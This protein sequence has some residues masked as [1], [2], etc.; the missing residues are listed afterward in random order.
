MKSLCESIARMKTLQ[1]DSDIEWNQKLS[2][3][4]EEFKVCIYVCMYV[5]VCMR[6]YVYMYICER[7]YVCRV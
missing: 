6:M 4:Q 7:M 5:C 1:R 3:S 2:C